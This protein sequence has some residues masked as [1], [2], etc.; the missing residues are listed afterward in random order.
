MVP[1]TTCSR[2]NC[3]HRSCASSGDAASSGTRRALALKCSRGATARSSRI[4]CGSGSGELG[5]R[6]ASSHSFERYI[7]PC[8]L[9]SPWP[10]RCTCSAR[11]SSSSTQLPLSSNR[12]VTD[13][14]LSRFDNLIS[15]D[16]SVDF[17]ACVVSELSILNHHSRSALWIGSLNLQLLRPEDF[18]AQRCR[19]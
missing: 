14:C 1:H 13:R 11:P 7:G 10:S 16:C 18:T 12:S 4:C 8:T 15:P 3:C 17:A 2:V 5:T 6:W 9:A 19:R